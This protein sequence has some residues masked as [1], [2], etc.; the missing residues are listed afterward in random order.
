[1]PILSI[2][3]SKLHQHCASCGATNLVP[4]ATLV[5]GAGVEGR[6]NP[7]AI[8]LPP[9][10]CGAREV[11]NRTWDRTPRDYHRSA[12]C[13]QRCAVNALAGYLKGR[14]QQAALARAIHAAEIGEPPEIM[15]IEDAVAVLL[16]ENTPGAAVWNTQ[17]VTARAGK[18]PQITFG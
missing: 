6:V 10:S 18:R 4:L 9:C 12:H 5:L 2:D 7:N 8:T 17:V 15:L 3:A 1:M 11:L 13:E 16:V 14:G